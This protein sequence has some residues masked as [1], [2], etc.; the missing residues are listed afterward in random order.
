MRISSFTDTELK[1]IRETLKVA[2]LYTLGYLYEHREE[3]DH[4]GLTMT[5]RSLLFAIREGGLR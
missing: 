2:I 3:A 5:L 4:H 1:S